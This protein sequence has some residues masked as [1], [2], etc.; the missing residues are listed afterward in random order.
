M[1]PNGKIDRKTLEQT[2]YKQKDAVITAPRNE[3]DTKIMN[4]WK[5]ILKQ[6]NFGI[7][8]NI[9]ENSLAYLRRNQ[10][11]STPWFRLYGKK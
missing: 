1:T 5:K 6:D 3:L 2:Y 9:F 7:D 8:D 4:A 10:N 11:V